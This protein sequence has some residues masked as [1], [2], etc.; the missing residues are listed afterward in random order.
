M[1]HTR[2]PLASAR[3]PTR[4]D[5]LARSKP[6][7]L[8]G[9][10]SAISAKNVPDLAAFRLCDRHLWLARHRRSLLFGRQLA[11]YLRWRPADCPRYHGLSSRK[12]RLAPMAPGRTLQAS[13]QEA[14]R[15]RRL[16]RLVR[17]E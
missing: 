15:S 6:R 7:R 5:R 11:R 14:A 12:P 17:F 2:R 13:D 4:I 3:P 1:G 9:K 10:T 16:L 8:R